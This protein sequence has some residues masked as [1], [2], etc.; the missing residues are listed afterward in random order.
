MSHFA[1]PKPTEV[2]DGVF[3]IDLMEGGRPFRTGAYLILDDEPTLIETGS[4][5][6]HA[7]LLSGM[8]E[9]GISPSDLAYIAVTHVHL[10]H[11]GGAGHMMAL[12]PQ[13]KLLVHPRGARHM[14]DPSRLWNGA[15]AVYGAATEQLFGEP[16]PIEGERIQ[17]QEHETSVEIGKRTLTFF[18]SP[19]HA[20]HHFTILDPVADAL[21]AG[22]AVGIRYRHEFTNLPFEFVMPSS[23]P[24]DFDPA[25]VHRTVNMLRALPYSSIF[26]THFGESP[27]AEA[28]EQTDRL[29]D[30][31][32][33]V[34]DETYRDG[35]EAR[36]V[37]EALEIRVRNR[38]QQDGHP[39]TNF[40]SIHADFEIDAMGLIYFEERRRRKASQS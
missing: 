38:L 22:D 40:S 7:A 8:S 24:V 9:I 1:Y 35:I 31:F 4:A 5:A 23:S 14:Q 20:S 37:A 18:D 6:S 16:V 25:A 34:I 17:I 15:K 11:A 10:D 33:N 32:A 39:V 19:G 2:R 30:L 27:K 12:A 26:H 3:L 28:L 36:E 29:A 13:A 21:Y